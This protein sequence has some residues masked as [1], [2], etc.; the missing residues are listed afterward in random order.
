MLKYVVCLCTGC[1]GCC[2]F[3]LY[4]TAW[5]CK[6]SCMGSVSVDADVVCVLCASCGS[7]QCCALHDFQFVNAG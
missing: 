1:D 5:S 3:C 2:I 6:C 7:S 4:C